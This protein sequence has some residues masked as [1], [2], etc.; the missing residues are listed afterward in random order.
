MSGNVHVSNL[1]VFWAVRCHCSDNSR[2]RTV[3][4]RFTLKRN[5]LRIVDAARVA[6]CAA[7]VFAFVT[8]D[9]AGFGHREIAHQPVGVVLALFMHQHLKRKPT[10]RFRGGTERRRT[11]AHPFDLGVGVSQSE[12]P[13]DRRCGN[14]AHMSRRVLAT[15]TS[16][17]V[18]LVRGSCVGETAVCR[19]CLPSPS[20]AGDTEVHALSNDRTV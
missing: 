11:P 7:D 18:F 8:R 12:L 13:A 16:G 10:E 6:D 2:P 4:A 1:D 14:P 19:A 9:L 20:I 17:I 5:G 3:P 15:T